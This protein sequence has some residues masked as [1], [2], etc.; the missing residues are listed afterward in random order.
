MARGN[1]I[2]T[3][4]SRATTYDDAGALDVGSWT[5]TGAGTSAGITSVRDTL[6]LPADAPVGSQGVRISVG[7]GAE[8]DDAVIPWPTGGNDFTVSDTVIA[9]VSSS[10][11]GDGFDIDLLA[12]TSPQ[13]R[14]ALPEYMFG[15]YLDTGTGGGGGGGGEDQPLIPAGVRPVGL[16]AR[17]ANEL[18]IEADGSEPEEPVRSLLSNAIDGASTFINGRA[19]TAPVDIKELAVLRMVGWLYDRDS[20]EFGASFASAY[21][22]SGAA[23]FL[24]SYLPRRLASSV[25]SAATAS[26]TGTSGSTSAAVDAVARSEARGALSAA[27]TARSEAQDAGRQATDNAEDIADLKVKDTELAGNDVNE[28][29]LSLSGQDLSVTVGRTTATDL[30]SRAVTLPAATGSGGLSTVASDATLT[31]DGSSGAPLS[32]ARPYTAQVE[33]Q[34]SRTRVSL[35]ALESKVDDDIADIKS[36]TTGDG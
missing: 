35:A 9:R 15:V 21:K 5:I 14:A 31:G 12:E 10:G 24:R 6:I 25:T 11:F 3:A 1:E 23:D 13:F 32:V 33:D 28:V 34:I 19:S 17:A 20:R 26:S 4:T 2:A 16:I 8:V 18:R 22:E 29:S 27:S 30:V 36:R 7:G